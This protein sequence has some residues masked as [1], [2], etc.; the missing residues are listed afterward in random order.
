MAATTANDAHDTLDQSS[1]SNNSGGAGPDLGIVLAL[2]AGVV[3]VVI[4]V[5]AGAVVVYRKRAAGG[6][7]N[8]SVIGFDNPMYNN[9]EGPADVRTP[10]GLLPRATCS[11]MVPGQANNL[12]YLDIAPTS[13]VGNTNNPGYMDVAPTSSAGYMDVSPGEAGMNGY[14][15]V[16]YTAGYTFDDT[17]GGND[18][19]SVDV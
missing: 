3:S 5:V 16:G 13:S 1:D 14:V 10:K 18:D 19:F 9:P 2:V 15:D 4:A 12:G 6:G 17:G 11:A 8:R 7:L